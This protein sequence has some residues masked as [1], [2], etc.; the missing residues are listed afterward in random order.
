MPTCCAPWPGKSSANDSSAKR[1]V[2]G[3]YYL[4]THVIPAVTAHAMR[5]HSLS[6]S[7]TKRQLPGCKK[8]MRPSGAGSTIG[9]P[10]FWDSHNYFLPIEKSHIIGLLKP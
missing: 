7:R 6:A 9:V 2:L 1:L 5:R 4:F 3:F 8:I 10:A